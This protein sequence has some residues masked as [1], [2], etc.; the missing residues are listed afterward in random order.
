MA[1]E[2]VCNPPPINSS[3]NSDDTRSDSK[4]EIT[5]VTTCSSSTHGATKMAEGEIPKLSDFFKKTTIT[6]KECQSYHDRDWLASNLIS[7]IPEVDVPTVHDST[8]IC[9]ESHLFTGLVLPPNKFLVSI[10]N[11]LS[12]ALVHFNLNAIVALSSFTM[13]C[14]CWLGISLDTSLFWY[15]YSPA[16]YNKTIYGGIG[17]SLRHHH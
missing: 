17:L 4:A 12:C 14:E 13:L 16:W 10:M 11:Y 5:A 6:N 1:E 2:I 15:Y 9:F 8:M 7:T 3:G